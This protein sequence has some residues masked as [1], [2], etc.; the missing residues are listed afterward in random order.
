M[1]TIQEQDPLESLGRDELLRVARRDRMVKE[2]LSNR[3]AA[4][5]AENAE[6]LAIIRDQQVDMARMQAP[7]PQDGDVSQPVS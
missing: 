6:L 7:V 2:M 4:L 1:T 5:F 3:I